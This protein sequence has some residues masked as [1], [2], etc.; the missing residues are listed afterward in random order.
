M[1]SL[2]SP[3]PIP[4]LL[5]S[6]FCALLSALP[7]ARATFHEMQI[8]QVIGGVDGD[9][10]AQA[11][12]LRMRVAGQNFVSNA[13][14]IAYDA[15][16]QNPIVLIQFPSDVT[17]AAAGSRILITSA[18]FASHTATALQSDFTMTHLIP[19]SYLAAGRIV[20]ASDANEILWSISFGGASYTGSNMGDTVNDA[21]GNFGP[22]FPD[23][24]PS[25]TA[26]ALLFQAN[27]GS[28]ST[29]NAADYR[30]TTGPATFF[31]NAG[32][33]A[34]L[35]SGASIQPITRGS[36]RVNLKS[37]G[38]AFVSPVDLTSAHDGTDRLFIVDQA[39]RLRLI[40]NGQLVAT[41]ALDLSTRLVPLS[42]SYD[43]RG[44][45][46]VAF[47][48]GFN[49]PASA[50]YRKLY[51]FTS[52]PVSGP[53]DFTVPM[54][55]A[56]DC[57]SVV[58]EWQISAGNPDLVDT[59]TR[60]EVLRIDK[61][62]SNHNGGKLAFSPADG[63]LYISTGDGGQANDQ[64]DG[65]G[66]SGNAQNVQNALGKILRI[67]PIDPALT[68]ASADPVS[69]NG[70]YRIP[71][72]NPSLGQGAVREIYAYGLRN[73]YRFSFDLEN[74]GE[75]LI[76]GD[77][78]QNNIE[79]IDIIEPG[80][81]YGWNRKE[82]TFLFDPTDG[83]IQLDPNPDPALTDPVL[84]YDHT[85]GVAVIGGFVYR[86]SAIPGLVGKYVFGDLQR[87]STGNGRLFYGDLA[88]GVIHELTIGVNQTPE[89][90]YL[91]GFGED[92]AGELYVLTSSSLGPI[93]TNGRVFQIV[94][95]FGVIVAGTGAGP[96]TQARVLDAATGLQL[97]QFPVQKPSF[98]G[99]IRVAV[100][101]VN[102][103]GVPDIITGTGRGVRPEVK[104]FDGVSGALLAD[105]MPYE[106]SFRGGVF[107]A[108]GDVNGVGVAEIITGP[109]PG[110]PP[111]VFIFPGL[112][113]PPINHFLAYDTSF[114]G[115]VRVAA[116]DLNGDGTS[117][118]ITGPGAGV[119]RDP[120][121]EIFKADGTPVGNIL[122]YDSKFHGGIF[123]AA[124]DVNG[125]GHD[126]IIT[127]PGSGT[128][129]LVK[130]FDPATG[131][132]I[133]SFLAKFTPAFRGGVH[134]AAVDTDGDGVTEIITSPASGA[135]SLIEVFDSQTGQSR[136]SFPAF[137]KGAGQGVFV[138]AGSK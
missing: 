120:R 2:P 101:D 32:G 55:G 102:G 124:G 18:S 122:A 22:P 54:T 39:G 4:R 123:V 68:P 61:P 114:R 85:E 134:V 125:N 104:V 49:D 95:V 40:K 131:A 14:L 83:S 59:A 107:V 29:N 44:F 12:Q 119:R 45:L 89:N 15:T 132:L 25:A 111:D 97:L 67:D 100:G 75:R 23:P 21:D 116:G 138:A 106:K 121:V 38:S 71:G 37:I 70:K 98:V 52:E 76:A 62:Q 90:W 135:K 43:E 110:R 66:A 117:L 6:I 74:G 53:A 3:A 51:T 105:F 92:A 30:L 63:Y 82:G 13:Q 96:K 88:T 48:P 115:G 8:E 128:S 118:I 57:Q 127:G 31:N 86:G 77:V 130:I 28:L 65:H 93:G 99:G 137:V 79:E 91:K 20:Y 64:G 33:S 9:I 11:I 129:P 42:S 5:A 112:G 113:G 80:K 58:A 73:P 50:G 136:E 26:Q 78:G 46:G 87:A 133:T 108:A 126:E 19:A 56:F 10:T 34:T 35:A 36:L 103:D 27:G 7:A 47:P 41:P 60:R 1:F 81:N 84:E 94:P 109:G 24:L 16:G 17:Q 72:S 69:A